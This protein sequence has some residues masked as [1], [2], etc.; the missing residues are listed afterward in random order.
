MDAELAKVRMSEWRKALAAT[1]QELVR[2]MVQKERLIGAI[3][4]V[5]G[6]MKPVETATQEQLDKAEVFP[7]A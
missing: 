1:E 3:S 6:L 4:A 2:L 7:H 5:E